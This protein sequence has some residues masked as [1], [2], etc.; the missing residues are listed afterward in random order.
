[1]PSITLDPVEI[2]AF[3]RLCRENDIEIPDEKITFE[4]WRD[5][6][7]DGDE[8]V[9]EELFP[10]ETDLERLLF[11]LGQACPICGETDC[12]DGVAYVG[13]TPIHASE[14]PEAKSERAMDRRGGH[15]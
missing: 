3:K 2:M 8:L 9:D 1:M 10:H 12:D 15:L 7:S 14:H 6:Q 11:D 13:S 5:E 4:E